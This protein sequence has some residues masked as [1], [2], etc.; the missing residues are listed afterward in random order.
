MGW[1][2]QAVQLVGA[3]A[4]AAVVATGRGALAVKVPNQVVEAALITKEAVI[5]T[6]SRGKHMIYQRSHLLLS[7]RQEMSGNR[8]HPLHDRLLNE[9]V[10]LDLVV[11]GCLLKQNVQHSSTRRWLAFLGP[12]INVKTLQ[13]T[14]TDW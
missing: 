14:A 3:A 2:A 11:W 5:L 6:S 9:I 8:R 10:L 4:R 1:S 13:L 7:H 12:K